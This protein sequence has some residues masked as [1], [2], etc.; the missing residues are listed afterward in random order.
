MDYI[1]A[2]PCELVIRI[3]SKL[4]CM[5][6][7]ASC[8][9]TCRYINSSYYQNP[10]LA[11]DIIKRKVDADRLKRL[12]AMSELLYQPS[13]LPELSYTE[14]ADFLENHP[15]RLVDRLRTYPTWALM[16][17]EADHRWKGKYDPR[18]P[19]KRGPIGGIIKLPDQTRSLTTQP[20]WRS[21]E[22]CFQ[23]LRGFR[24]KDPVGWLRWFSE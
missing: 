15:N 14:V 1:T 6:D 22:E 18:N 21:E 23:P 8:L 2:L 19:A 20:A 12:I 7:L 5:E 13:T 16:Q 17:V 3:L 4:P 11:V 10:A 9:L 24:P